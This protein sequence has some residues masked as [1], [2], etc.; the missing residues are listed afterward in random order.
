VLLTRHHLEAS[1]REGAGHGV[2]VGLSFPFLAAPPPAVLRGE[3]SLDETLR[4]AALGDAHAALAVALLRHLPGAAPSRVYVGNETCERLLP[5]PQAI[6]SWIA[7]ARRGRVALSLVLPPLSRDG[8]ANAEEAVRALEGVEDSEVVANDWGTVHR[9]RARH[10]GLAIV[11][12]RL[13][14]KMLRDPRLA[15]YF[16]SP[17]APMAA[18]AALCRSGELA[19]GFR[20]LME[21][22][23]IGRR[24][25]DP[26]L[27]PLEADEWE[28]RSEKLS[29]HFPY[30]FVTMG[31]ACL[32]GAMHRDPAEKFLPGAPCRSECRKYTVEFRLPVPGGNGA[33]KNLL[34]LGNAYYHAVPSSVTERILGFLPS[35]R[36]VDR[37]VVTVPTDGDGWHK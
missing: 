14:H 26:F 23:S 11:L 16:D 17:Q 22:Y 21:R 7:L 30:L 34:N 36:Q 9:L 25:I 24:E 18:R 31:R 37:I 27:Q 33:G 12:G 10:P 35:R 19:P 28:N 5:T 6:G 20:A 29:V 32:L 4:G 15:E 13:T 1:P 2:E 3:A 8:L